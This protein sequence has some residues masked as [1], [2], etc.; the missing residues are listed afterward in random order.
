MAAALDRLRWHGIETETLDAPAQMDVDRFV[1]QR[2]LTRSDHAFEN[3]HE[4]RSFGDDGARRVRWIRVVLIRANQRL[5]R[6]AFY[7][8]EPDSDDGLATWNVIDEAWSVRAI[9]LSGALTVAHL[10]QSALVICGTA[11][12]AACDDS[13]H[14]QAARGLVD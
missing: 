14:R 5:A 8:L 3:H 13:P 7:L 2:H 11:P 1:I 10:R 4:A 12:S 9:R 6:L